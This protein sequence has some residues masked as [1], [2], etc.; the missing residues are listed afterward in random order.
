[1]KY[2]NLVQFEPVESVIEL[3]KAD[4]ADSARQL[5]QTF[6]VSDRMAEQLTG[7]VF[8][9]LRYDAPSDNKG[10]L[11]VGN[12][13]T[14]KSH[15]MALISAIAEFGDLASVVNHSGV[16]KAAQPVA[17]RFR[18]IRMET[19]STTMG[20][21]DL[22]CRN[23]EARLALLGVA[24]SFPDVAEVVSNKDDFVAM[25]AAFQQVYPDQGLLLVLDELLDYLRTREEQALILDL[26]FLREIGE[27]CKSTR[28]RFISG[29]QESLFD[30][31]RFE[32][33]ADTLRRVK[34]RFAQVRI[35]REDVA[36]V[37]SER[38]LKKTAEQ[39]A[40][41][42]EHLARFSKLYGDMNERMDR[43][44][45]LF[46][47]HPAYLDTFER[48]YVAEKREVLKTMSAAIRGM[49]ASD[50]PSDQPG[51]IAYDGYWAQL[52]D[53][54]SFRSLPEIRKV[55]ERSQVLEGRVK[56]GLSR[57]RNRPVALRI[58]H[59]L[60]VHRLTTGD[61]FAPI[62]ASSEELR[63]DLCLMVPG[64]PEEDPEF[65]RTLIESVLADIGRTVSGQFLSHNKENGQY[66][67]DLDKD[68]DFDSLIE[69]KAEGLGSDQLNRYYFD[70][71]AQV[72]EVVDLQPSASGYRIW[73]YA[74]EWRERRAERPGYLFFGAPNERSTAQP[75]RDFYIY[76]IQPF[77]PPYFKDEGKPDE[78]LLRLR[79][80]D[81]DFE[82]AL[83]LYAGARE[84]A[85]TA[86]GSNK[87]TYLDKA[88][89]HLRVLTRRLREHATTAFE[90]TWQNKARSLAETIQG[91]VKG[92]TSRAGVRDF[93]NTA[94]SACLAPHFQHKS[95]DYPIFSLLITRANLPQAAQEAV[96][97][98]A[99]NSYR[100]RQAVAVLDA[101]EL[102][103]GE[104]LRPRNSRYARHVLD[105]LTTKQR[106]QVLTR[107][108]LVGDE[109]G[110]EYWTRFRVE[111]QLLAVVIVALVHAGSIELTVPGK[112]LDAGNLERL[113]G[114]RIQ[115]IAAFKHLGQ[116]K[117]LPLDALQELFE[118]L[119][120]PK[121][122]IVNQ[123]T[124]EDAVSKLQSSAAALTQRVVNAQQSIRGAFPFWGRPILSEAEHAEWAARLG[125]LKAFLESLQ[126][127]NTVGKLKNFPHD[128]AAVE[129][130]RLGVSM[131]RD[132]DILV[133]LVSQHGPQTGWLTTAEA[134]LPEAHQWRTAVNTARGEMLTRL[135]SPQHRKEQSFHRELGQTLT[136]LMADYQQ[137]YRQLHA[138]QRL[139]TS[140][141]DKKRAL[142]VDPRLKQLQKL[143]GVEMMTEQQLQAF[144][145]RLL[146]LRTCFS[147]ETGDLDTAPICP[148]CQFR[149][150][151][152]PGD[153]PPVD[154]HL[155]SLDQQL[156]ALARD[157]SSTLLANLADPMVAP[158]IE[159]LSDPA[160]KEA[161]NSF[162]SSK[163]LPDP[164]S[165]T[166]VKA[167]NEMLG[168]LEKVLVAPADLRQ[169]LVEGGT[170]CTVD[171][172][173]ERFGGF[174][175]ALT[176]GKDRS[177]IR[178]VVE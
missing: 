141:D 171:E 82:Q 112:K 174:V 136:R 162:L 144:E 175:D 154:E 94:A 55:V 126:P 51:L 64:L 107:A 146:G 157:W 41:I 45:D 101:L 128:V 14:G 59:A 139:G 31:G 36:F 58:I 120:L 163:T 8:P 15:L 37:V 88:A 147:L 103:D 17:G 44:V 170:P 98:I 97:A 153:G 168:G 68:V 61:I 29:V 145:N 166:F 155:R 33:V 148:H 67:L 6:V 169:S 149:P 118:L 49:L 108:E 177:K 99:M 176:R 115:D 80:P 158:N 137:V 117:D 4:A 77:D 42:R 156:D 43:Y 10:L 78:V 66:Y 130:Q 135:A 20:L 81:D 142:T 87:Q 21:R 38:I 2:R 7:L 9:H 100:H 152:E 123:N 56:H 116:P 151:E 111:P 91:K 3:R 113:A 18:V 26:N 119:G 39:R 172:L 122:L 110:V 73:E 5:V 25:M 71:L 22:V 74:V 28:F 127:F 70:A 75:P 150:V 79:H 134:L 160:G 35:A 50:V 72:M 105:R 165:A 90:V 138:R 85:L 93:V 69:K 53:N 12:Y 57:T 52:R 161:V 129:A 46:P 102:M 48:V 62:G 11:V 32:F 106:G 140:G 63:D 178:V 83:R 164:V 19:T 125:S 114:I 92:G 16:A 30:S 47:V 27:V 131:L 23:L 84:Q 54:P 95:P 13:G 34:D 60:S 167:V 173:K 104:V 89:A 96:R 132:V 121:G 159:L 24:H 76:F 109:S 1:M 86:S 143:R 65:L 124:H 40:R 133:K